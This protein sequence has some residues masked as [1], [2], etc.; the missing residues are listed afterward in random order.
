MPFCGSRPRQ[1][2][3][4]SGAPVPGALW[5]LPTMLEDELH[6]GPWQSVLL[7]RSLLPKAKY[8]P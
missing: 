7:K 6:H 3:V 8:G 5:Q 1:G 4:L 2:E